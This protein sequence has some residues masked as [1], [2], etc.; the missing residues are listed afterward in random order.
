MGIAFFCADLCANVELAWAQPH[1]PASQTAPR[2]T[3]SMTIPRLAAD[4]LN[5]LEA[6]AEATL[7]SAPRDGQIRLQITL[8]NYDCPSRNGES[9]DLQAC[10]ARDPSPL[11]NIVLDVGHSHHTDSN[12]DRYGNSSDRSPDQRNLHEG[13]IVMSVSLMAQDILRSCYGLPA[14][15]VHLSRYPGEVEFGTFHNSNLATNALERF[16]ARTN[17]DIASE[18]DNDEPQRKAFLTHLM[19][20]GQESA[21]TSILVS[22]HANASGGDYVASFYPPEDPE[23]STLATRITESIVAQARGSFLDAIAAL[24]SEIRAI[25]QRSAAAGRPDPQSE[26]DL[27]ALRDKVAVLNKARRTRRSARDDATSRSIESDLGIFRDL[28]EGAPRVLSEGFFM[29]GILGQMA[30][31][32]INQNRSRLLNI[33]AHQTQARLNHVRQTSV[34]VVPEV[35]DAREGRWGAGTAH[36]Y[37]VTK[38]FIDYAKG[39]GAGLAAQALAQ[40]AED[41]GT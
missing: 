18:L 41:D 31:A 22:V 37:D 15:K 16:Q 40:C 23:S 39:L 4:N 11:G 6:V 12:L 21:E 25:E 1:A 27:R 30:D 20:L 9:E 36:K 5:P 38:I 19:E 10:L 34:Q 29:D 7:D 2:D 8:P 28:G 26:A 24:Q 33:P 35:Y 3:A 14:N 13:K 17:N 32:E